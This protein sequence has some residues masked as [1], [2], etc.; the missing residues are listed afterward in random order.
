MSTFRSV[1]ESRTAAPPRVVSLPASAWATTWKNRQTEPVKV[2][3]RRYSE[4]DARAVSSAASTKAC[5]LH[6]GD[7]EEDERVDAH[8]AT[9]MALVVARSACDPD[10]FAISYFG[11]DDGTGADDVVPMALTP[12]GIEFLYG[13]IDR[14]LVEESPI[15]AEAT[16]DDLAWLAGALT[17]GEAWGSMSVAAVARARR[18][19]ANVIEQ[20]RQ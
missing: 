7:G 16:D 11:R 2:G 6:P 9:L 17:K 8:N 12:E 1:I 4:G 15:G 3:L 13:E 5:R 14:M 10:D 18:L 19:L 20:L